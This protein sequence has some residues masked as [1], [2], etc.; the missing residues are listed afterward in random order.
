MKTLLLTKN[1]IARTVRAVGAD[2]IMDDTIAALDEAC[3]DFD[4]ARM[5]V[6]PRT[7]FS[8]DAPQVGLIEWMPVIEYGAEALVKVVGFHPRN[9]DR[10]GVPSVLSTALTVDTATGHVTSIVDATFMTSVRTGAAS[11]V[12]SRVLAV[13]ESRTVGLI[14]AGAQAVT[15]LHGLARVFDIDRVLLHDTD[16]ATVASF[17]SRIACAG[18]AF[19]SIE[20]A[21]TDA[22]V[23]AADIICT[24]T[25]QAVGSAALFDDVEP[26]A[27]AHFNAV[28]SDFPGKIELPLALLRRALVCPDFRDQAVVEGECQ[29]LADAEIGPDLVTLV[30]D[31]DR[32][33]PERRRITVFDSTGFALEDLVAARVITRRARECGFGEDV[34]L[35]CV[36]EDPKSP[37][38]FA[39]G[40]HDTLG[41]AAALARQRA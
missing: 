16:P 29:Q 41:V 13:P 15:Q 32:F 39:A 21:A 34:A 2:R 25:S 33:A 37:Y 30:R 5:T 4:A 3:R 18:L 22:I 1:D 12:A 17:A 11:A 27:H 24:A 40:A 10:A 23:G 31:P 36:G 28:G 26:L 14:G 35:A 20:R 7:G 9:P 19:R 6:P 8:Y 38:G